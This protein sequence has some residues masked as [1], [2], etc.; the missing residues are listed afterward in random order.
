LFGD[1]RIDSLEDLKAI[2]VVKRLRQNTGT[3]EVSESIGLLRKEQE[4]SKKIIVEMNE[5][6][7]KFVSEVQLI[8][9]HLGSQVSASPALGKSFY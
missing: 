6:F 7:K 9:T 4:E 2:P 3:E 5:Q 1:N 8:V